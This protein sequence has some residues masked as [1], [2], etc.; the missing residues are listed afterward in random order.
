MYYVV[1]VSD[2]ATLSVTV[3]ASAGAKA[4]V[5]QS[6]ISTCQR[7]NEER[8]GSWTWPIRILESESGAYDIT[9]LHVPVW[10]LLQCLDQVPFDVRVFLRPSS[11]HQDAVILQL[12]P[13]R[14]KCAVMNTTLLRTMLNDCEP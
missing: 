14:P 6:C 13:S 5:L 3:P 7:A 8:N 12:S 10:P 4:D 2:G 9:L 1:C 11:C